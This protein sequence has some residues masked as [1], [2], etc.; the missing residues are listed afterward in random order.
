MNIGPASLMS[1]LTARA[2]ADSAREDRMSAAAEARLRDAKAAVETMKQRRSQASEER[3]AIA[4]Q[5]VEQLK[6]RLQALRAMASVDPKGTARMAAQLAR[7]LGAAVKAYAAAGGTTTG[8]E[9]G[10]APAADAGAP[11]PGAEAEVGGA[12]ATPGEAGTEAVAATDPAQADGEVDG[13]ARG[14][15]DEGGAPANPYQQAIDEQKAQANET[16]RRSAEKQADTDFMAEVRK[17][18]SE[19]K[20]LVRQAVEKKPDD[21]DA[22]SPGEAGD[23]RAMVADMD[24]EIAQATADLGGGLSL[25]V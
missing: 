5:K 3:K 8:M 23:L 18:A 4:R 11:A 10:A 17:L 6:A 21:K 15:K 22:M 1:L 2:P 19:L 7:E 14:D 25:L 13:E 9:T 24:R 16:A 20:A 12:Q